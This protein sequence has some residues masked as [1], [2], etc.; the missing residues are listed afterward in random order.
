M[1]YAR[2]P[3]PGHQFWMSIDVWEMSIDVKTKCLITIIL[4]VMSINVNFRQD[5]S[6]LA[7]N[8][9]FVLYVQIEKSEIAKILFACQ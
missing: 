2:L 4:P 1:L 5:I 8:T 3:T 9:I 7:D 6:C